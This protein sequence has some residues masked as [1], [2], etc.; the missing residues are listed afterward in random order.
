L[1]SGENKVNQIFLIP[2]LFFVLLTTVNAEELY[3]CTDS[4][5]KKVITSSPQDGMKCAAGESNDE[6]SSPKKASKSKGISS[7][8]VVDTCEN[9]YRESE[10]ISDEIQSFNPLLSELQR[11]QFDIRQKSV[12]ENWNYKTESKAAKHIRDEQYKINQQISLLNQKQSLISNDIRMHKCDQIKQDLSRL[13]HGN[14]T[15]NNPTSQKNRKSTFIM[16]N[17]SRSVIIRD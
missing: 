11:E 6:P 9:L 14:V 10:K 4:N 13:N 1:L 15:I 3:N 12:N 16:R 7:E 2:F 8:N 5:G 17:G